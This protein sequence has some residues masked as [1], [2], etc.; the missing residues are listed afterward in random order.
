VTEMTGAE[1]QRLLVQGFLA[2]VLYGRDDVQVDQ[3]RDG[4]GTYLPWFDVTTE[5][6]ARARVH[7]EQVPAREHVDVAPDTAEG[8]AIHRAIRRALRDYGSSQGHPPDLLASGLVPTLDTDQQAFLAGV[9]SS[10]AVMALAAERGG[11]GSAEGHH[12]PRR[13]DDPPHPS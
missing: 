7:V 4:A 6:G 1:A 9:L 11:R 3:G 12:V 8:L 10:R 5:M 2:G 13:D